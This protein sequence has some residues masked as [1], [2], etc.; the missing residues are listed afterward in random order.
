MASRIVPLSMQRHASRPGC[1]AAALTGGN[2]AHGLASATSQVG[3]F[4]LS[5][6]DI[7][8]MTAVVD[9]DQDEEIDLLPSEPGF[10][11]NATAARRFDITPRCHHVPDAG[12]R[13]HE[14]SRRDRCIM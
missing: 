1:S 8:Q 14:L 6:G 7:A 13:S 4:P 11:A 9:W 12:N 3:Q 2:V 5:F 10:H